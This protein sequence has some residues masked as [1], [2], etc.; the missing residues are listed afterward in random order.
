[1]Q[2]Q[3]GMASGSP[4]VGN[5]SSQTPK[6]TTKVA[7]LAVDDM[8]D[9]VGDDGAQQRLQLA[10]VDARQVVQR[11]DLG[12]VQ[13]VGRLLA[14]VVPQTAPAP[15]SKEGQVFNVHRRKSST[16]TSCHN[17]RFDAVRS[18]VYILFGVAAVA[19]EFG[20]VDELHAKLEDL[21]ELTAAPVEQRVD[22]AQP[23]QRVEPHA[24]Q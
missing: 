20:D 14:E 6:P 10:R 11:V 13:P 16:W 24:L 8:F 7:H 23:K 17:Q 15:Q 3:F 4:G 22:V 21:V 18:R 12:V 19:Q 9:A 5:Q 1:M 2:M